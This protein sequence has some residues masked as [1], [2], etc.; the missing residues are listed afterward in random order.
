[1]CHAVEEWLSRGEFREKPCCADRP[2]PGHDPSFTGYAL[3]N[4]EISA[5]GPRHPDSRNPSHPLIDRASGVP[6]RIAS[7]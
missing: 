2:V 7:F 1:M 6:L 4:P 3:L 5:G